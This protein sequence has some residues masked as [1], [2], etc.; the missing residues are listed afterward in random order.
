LRKA[1]LAEAEKLNRARAVSLEFA[2]LVKPGVARRLGMAEDVR[3]W[4]TES[5]I[6]NA[7]RRIAGGKG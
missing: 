6:K 4:T 1:I 3:G 7:S 5:A 2:G